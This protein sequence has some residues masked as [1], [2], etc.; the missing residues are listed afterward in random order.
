M[1]KLEIRLKLQEAI[2]VGLVVIII[3]TIFFVMFV[4]KPQMTKL[5]EIRR[6]IEEEKKKSE[7]ATITLQR[8]QA[9]KQ[10]EAEIE[11]SLIKLSLRMPES[12]ELPSLIVELQEL[13]SQSGMDLISISPSPPTSVG[14][15]NEMALSLNIKGSFNK[16]KD[17]GGS[18]LDFLY[19]LEHF[20]REL[21]VK[22]ISISGEETLTISL[23][24]STYVLS[25]APPA[26]APTGQ[27]AQQ[28]VPAAP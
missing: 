1:G 18:L 8:L 9:L 17:Q 24:M 22:T 12:P 6:A 2:A 10:E 14:E 23:Q 13:A 20:P 15:Y 4:W 28:E 19:R 7:M 3:L 21:R 5:S 25:G 11:K 16:V 26:G 27:P